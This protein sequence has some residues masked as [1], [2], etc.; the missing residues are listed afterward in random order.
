[1]DYSFFKD[2]P[3]Y[4]ILAYILLHA[5]KSEEPVLR[6]TLS[7]NLGYS[8]D[9]TLKKYLSDMQ[10]GNIIEKGRGYGLKNQWK[11]QFTHHTLDLISELFAYILEHD[12]I[13]HHLIIEIFLS[14]GYRTFI[15][16]EPINEYISLFS[17]LH[18]NKYDKQLYDMYHESKH[19]LPSFINYLISENTYEI[20]L[21]NNIVH[22]NDFES[23]SNE[24][25]NIERGF[26]YL[27]M[28]S[29]IGCDNFIINCFKKGN[30]KTQFS[31]SILIYE[32]EV[33]L[34]YIGEILER[35]IKS[36]KEKWGYVL[37]PMYDLYI[38]CLNYHTRVNYPFELDP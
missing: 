31:D 35:N 5:N 27:S 25:R 1:M 15:D 8:N 4:A 6:D 34:E 9:R 14:K 13:N 24:R 20:G 16:S 36:F 30:F 18:D 37:T 32:T 28:L 3:Q 17:L 22:F 23:N 33:P 7:K 12:F 38:D 29:C 26:Y 21:F 19:I 11:L 10:I 2:R